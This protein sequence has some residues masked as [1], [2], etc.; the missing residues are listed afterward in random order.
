MS[1]Y[2]T[3]LHYQTCPINTKERETSPCN[4]SRNT[5]KALGREKKK[6]MGVAR[7]RQPKGD[8]A[9]FLGS[10]C[11]HPQLI[12]PNTRDLTFSL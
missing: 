10:A 3:V 9:S 4:R 6:D 1:M 5:A 2:R 12:M 11:D 8:I 7:K